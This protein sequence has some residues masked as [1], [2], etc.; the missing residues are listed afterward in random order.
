MDN[1][2]LGRAFRGN[3]SRADM[4]SRARVAGD[5]AN[6]NSPFLKLGKL[7][8]SGAFCDNPVYVERK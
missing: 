6:T 3:T 8:L 4:L 5:S 1:P 2:Q 7:I